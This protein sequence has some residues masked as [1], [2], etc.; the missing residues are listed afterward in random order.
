M[1]RFAKASAPDQSLVRK[2]KFLSTGRAGTTL[3]VTVEYTPPET[4][5][6]MNEQEHT[7]IVGSRKYGSPEDLAESNKSLRSAWHRILASRV[8]K[9]EGMTGRRL[10][11]LVSLDPAELA[12]IEGGLDSEIKLDPSDATEISDAKRAELGCED[13]VKTVGQLASQ[14]ILW[15]VNACS[16]FRLFLETII[17]DV[18]Y[19]QDSDWEKQ[20]KN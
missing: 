4:L 19:F 17:K 1:F 13:G 5:N 3:D 6:E 11:S 7:R 18:G 14:N 2:I 15:L 8:R 9:I 10:A 20:V 16:E 12:S